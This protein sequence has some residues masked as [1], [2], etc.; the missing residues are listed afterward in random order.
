MQ[1]TP[2]FIR[3]FADRR[4][5]ACPPRPANYKLANPPRELKMEI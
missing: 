2:R 3:E 4:S 1:P 5:F